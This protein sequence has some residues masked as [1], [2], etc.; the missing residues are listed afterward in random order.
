MNSTSDQDM[1]AYVRDVADSAEGEPT[2]FAWNFGAVADRLELLVQR[3]QE[4]TGAKPASVWLVFREAVYRHECVGV[5]RSD[6]LARAAADEQVGHEPDGHH[7]V[8]VYG[9]WLVDGVCAREGRVG[10]VAVP[11]EQWDGRGW[12]GAPVP[13]EP[14]KVYEVTRGDAPPARAGG[15]TP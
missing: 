14:P 10:G 6:A 8:V 9:P 1:I 15:T 4:L 12:Y 2:D 7:S 13:T 11:A 3:V 5:F